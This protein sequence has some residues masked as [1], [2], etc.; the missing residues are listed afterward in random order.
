VL[1]VV[2]VM[3]VSPDLFLLLFLSL[4]LLAPSSFLFS[5]FTSLLT[6]PFLLSSSSYLRKMGLVVCGVRR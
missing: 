5:P 6:L 2:V 4:C 3:V 1:V